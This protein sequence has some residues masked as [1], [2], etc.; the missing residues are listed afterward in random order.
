MLGNGKLKPGA[1]TR[2][3]QPSTPIPVKKQPEIPMPPLT[4]EDDEDE[5]DDEIE[6]CCLEEEYLVER[7][8]LYDDTD[9]NAS[10]LSAEKS[11]NAADLDDG[12]I[13]E[14]GASL[15]VKGKLMPV[16]FKAYRHS[17]IVGGN[18][19]VADELLKDGGTKFLDLM[20]ALSKRKVVRGGPTYP[21]NNNSNNAAA[22]RGVDMDDAS[23]NDWDDYDEGSDDEDYEEDDEVLPSIVTRQ[24]F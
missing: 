7:K 13:I 24:L 6:D 3:L 19:T 4:R 2:K 22:V 23:E 17:N 1:S 15:T 9:L 12:S 10:P 8:A 11:A 21:N 5:F 14:F 18:L 20:E 16:L